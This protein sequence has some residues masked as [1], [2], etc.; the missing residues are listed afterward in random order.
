MEININGQRYDDWHQV[1]Q[2]IRSQLAALPDADGNGIPDILEG[3]G[4]GAGGSLPQPTIITS[5]SINL[6]GQPINSLADLPPGVIDKIR[7]AGFGAFLEPQS[8]PAS[9][10]N[11]SVPLASHQVVM[12]G[13]VVDV[14][15]PSATPRRWWQFWK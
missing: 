11:P 15:A 6:N 10:E 14:N 4:F 2:E 12:N 8:P 1:P 7:A 3:K 5:S 13:Q 9:T